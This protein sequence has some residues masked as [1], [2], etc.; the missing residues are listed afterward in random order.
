MYCKP[1]KFTQIL[2]VAVTKRVNSVNYCLGQRKGVAFPPLARA[3]LHLSH[4]QGYKTLMTFSH[5]WNRWLGSAIRLA[6][7]RSLR[8]ET[9]E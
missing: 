2:P 7:S 8:A 1:T 6:V 3:P 9:G 4:T 5:G